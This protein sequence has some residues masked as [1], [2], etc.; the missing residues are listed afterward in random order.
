MNECTRHGMASRRFELRLGDDVYPQR[1]ADSPHPPAILRGIGDP[2]LLQRSAFAVVGARKA[3]PYG[4]RAA[5]EFA[6]WAAGAG[7]IIV[8]GAAMGCDQA[9]HRAALAAGGTTVAVL[10]CGA[11]IVY[12]RGADS[13]LSEIAERGAIVSELDWGHPPS[14]W[15]FRARNRIIAGLADALLVV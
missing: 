11:D 3:T 15:T 5:S 7:H 4:R 10:G 12:P 9:A 1:L 13:L 6:G 8:S 14:K 2:S